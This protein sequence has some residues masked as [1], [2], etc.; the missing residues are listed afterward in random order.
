MNNTSAVNNWEK[1]FNYLSNILINKLK[2]GEYLVIQ[3]KAEHSH[4]IRFNNAKVRQNGIVID[5][6]VSLK[7]IANQKIAYASFP[8][9]ADQKIDLENALN[10][11]DY[12]REQISQIPEDPNIVLPKFQESSYEVYEGHLL[13]SVSAIE[14]IFPV[15]QDLDFTGL[16]AS[17]N[18]IRANYNSLGQKHWFATE[19]F[20]LDYSLINQDNKSIKGIICD[21]T[22]N[23]EYYQAQ[24]KE[25]KQQLKQLNLPVREI[26]PGQYRTYLAPDAM[27]D[28]VNMFSWDAIGES[29][30]RQG[31]SPLGKMKQGVTLS[32]LFS[33]KENFH[34]GNVPRF[35]DFGEI[36]ALELPLIVQGKL[37]NTLINSRTAK[38]YQLLSNGA[39]AQEK[40]RS[41][42]VSIGTLPRSEILASLDTGLYIS[43][44]HY[45]NWS[46]HHQGKIT[47]M[48]RYGCFWVEKGKIV[49][50]IKDLRFDESLYQIFGNKLINLTTFS[51]NIPKVSTYGN[52]SL[53]GC[54]TP[55]ALIDH[56]TFTL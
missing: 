46:D 28:L 39:N 11:L 37:I 2:E 38:E 47:G 43:N 33:L 15:A 35:N 14:H 12:L 8:L 49:A 18:I 45:L 22:W 1:S 41:P 54:V 34:S 7:L 50:T 3:L 29:C 32:P 9:T 21:R 16:Y 25:K 51:E 4:F 56:F 48:T 17:G 13:S 24:I 52:R 31:G 53:G 40:M 27:A 44:L 30:L 20:L 5:G 23:D 10:N 36:S 42:E 55:G 19:S 26:K 6:Q